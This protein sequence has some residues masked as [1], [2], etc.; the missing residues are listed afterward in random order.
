MLDQQSLNRQCFFCSIRSGIYQCPKCNLF[1][2][3]TNCFRSN[4]H[5]Q[6]SELFFK[7]QCVE[8]MKSGDRGNDSKKM[9][10]ILDRVK[11]LDEQSTMNFIQ[12]SSDDCSED[13][14]ISENQLPIN[15]N[16]DDEHLRLEIDKHILDETIGQCLPGVSKPWW[17]DP[18]THKNNSTTKIEFPLLS[19]ITCYCAVWRKYDCLCELVELICKYTYCRN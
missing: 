13:D 4:E 3:G 15:L 17:L 10:E 7:Q 2:C 16:V 19:K 8:Y 14:S 9:H 18:F 5:L 11:K 12:D 6:C 1:Y